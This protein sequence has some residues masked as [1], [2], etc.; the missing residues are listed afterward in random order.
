LA[1]Q[2]AY[3]PE[4]ESAPPPL[5][6]FFFRKR[7]DTDEPV[8]CQRPLQHI[9]PKVKGL[10]QGKPLPASRAVVPAHQLVILPF[11]PLLALS[12]YAEEFF[13]QRGRIPLKL[14]WNLI[15]RMALNR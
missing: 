11:L 1:L 9:E 14:L 12:G 15:A 2:S 6:R 7:R 4:L 13:K 5:S 10:S 8:P 3:G